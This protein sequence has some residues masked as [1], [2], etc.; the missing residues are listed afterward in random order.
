MQRSLHLQYIIFPKK[1]EFIVKKSVAIVIL[2][3]YKEA[4]EYVLE[5]L[6]KLSGGLNYDI[7]IVSNNYEILEGYRAHKLNGF[8]VIYKDNWDWE[9]L[10]RYDYV[11]VLHDADLTS[12]EKPSCTG[13]SYFYLVWENLIKNKDHL[14]GI[15]EKFEKDVRLGFLAPPQP[16]FADYFGDLD[17][18]WDQKHE[19][20]ERI[21]KRL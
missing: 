6:S 14:W 19:I 4:L 10:C 18:E 12:N 1:R 20:I 2:V 17:C 11:C 21:V 3:Q 7:Q 5:Y 15:L 8:K 16:I 9:E 13:K